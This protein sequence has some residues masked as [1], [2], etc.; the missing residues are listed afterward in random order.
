MLIPVLFTKTAVG[1]NWDQFENRH[2]L[3]KMA[4]GYSSKTSHGI[5]YRHRF[6]LMP[7]FDDVET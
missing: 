6:D 4:R 2:V 3:V 1:Q 5:G 7:D